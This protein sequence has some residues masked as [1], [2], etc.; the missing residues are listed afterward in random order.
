[1]LL[2]TLFSM[3]ALSLA[4][5]GCS[6][7]SK[8]AT[9]DLATAEEDLSTPGVDM[10]ADNDL[11][12]EPD[13]AKPPPSMSF[14]ITSRT[15]SASLGGLAGADA[16][17]QRLAAA[18][19]STRKWAAYLSAYAADGQAAVNARDRIGRG[20][21]YNQKL[22]LV[23]NNL[24]DLHNQMKMDTVNQMTGVDERGNAVP[25]NQHDILT[26]SDLMGRVNGMA[27]CRNW[28]FEMDVANVNAAVGHFNRAGGGMNPMSWNFAHTS[29]GCSAM[30]LVA[31]AGA[32]RFYCFATD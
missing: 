29:R 28:T 17:C 12:V 32:G 3:T 2:R 16:I 15:G 13:L 10:K 31:S 19:G 20:P 14:F 25:L 23:A 30:A 7:D 24:D 1:M 4:L 18:A 11:R 6:G 8:P 9:Q 26:G 22:A 27:T 5:A 21:W